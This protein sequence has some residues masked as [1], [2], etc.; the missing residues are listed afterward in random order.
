MTS[1]SEA[2]RKALNALHESGTEYMIVGSYAASVHGFTRATHDLDIVVSL[3]PQEVSKL[4]DA[5]GDEFFL[6]VE[7]ARDAVRR[8]E[9]FNAIHID[10]GIRV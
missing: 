6:D 4:A 3:R 10:S 8:G 2:V 5:L 9:M 7:P 1:E